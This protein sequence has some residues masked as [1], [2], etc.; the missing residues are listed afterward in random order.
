[1]HQDRKKKFTRCCELPNHY[2]ADEEW[3]VEENYSSVLASTKT[4]NRGVTE[5]VDNELY[6]T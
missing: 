4:N 1:M 6:G 2:R 3:A 5:L